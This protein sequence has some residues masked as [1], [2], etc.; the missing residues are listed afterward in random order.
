MSG[1]SAFEKLSSGI[2]QNER[3]KLLERIG[4]FTDTSDR[5]LLSADSETV[6]PEKT[7]TPY[8]RLPWYKRFWFSVLGFFAGKKSLDMFVNS[9]IADIGRNI[10]L[11]YPGIFYWQKCLL[12]QNFQ[13]EL[14]KL[15]EAARFFY[16]VFD[17][18][19]SRNRGGFFVFL[20]SFEMPELHE[21]LTEKTIPANFAVENPGFPDTKLRQMAINYVEHEINDIGEE[22]HKIMYSNA[23]TIVCLKQLSSYLFDRFLISFRQTTDDTEAVC[24]V[25]SVKKQIINLNDIL[26]SIKKTPSTT[27]LSA[28]LMFL[29]PEREDDQNYNVEKELQKFTAQAEKAIDVIRTFNHRVPIT[30][31]LRCVFRD[32]S[33]MPVEL[34]GGEDWFVLFRNS[35]VENVTHRFDEYIKER[36]RSR[37][38]DLYALLFE[39]AT[40]EPFENMAAS[41]DDEGIPIE[42][43]E[44]LSCLLA[45]HKIIFMPII[46]VFIRPVLIDGDFIKKENKMEFTEAYNVLI[47]LD[48]TIKSFAN[49][50]K[51]SGDLGKR[52]K[53]IEGD[54]RSITTRHRKKAIIWEE[55]NNTAVNIVS[56]AQ[57]SLTSLRNI[58]EGFVHPLKNNS[59]DS[60]SNLSKVGGKMAN[61][62]EGLVDA[63]VKLDQM[64]SLLKE[65]DNLKEMD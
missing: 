47:K 61:F 35:W 24:P 10:D 62:T 26:F 63:V 2:S 34:S 55:I 23:H 51:L 64:I 49:R 12:R 21:K 37:I 56:D 5:L 27:L 43:T 39:D 1:G 6:S 4:S 18:T 28:M 57:K 11:L 31:I 50:L 59:Y 42:D 32:T 36:C 15:K 8:F 9:K 13:T 30:S 29:L 54:I 52:W 19:I 7:E 17:S 58:L 25:V 65:L 14:K 60:L 16:G 40:V 44:S 3:V 22:G 53:Q 46:N 48:D 45:F 20:G 38:N 33:Y 41:S